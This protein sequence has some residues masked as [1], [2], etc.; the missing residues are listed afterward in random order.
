MPTKEELT[1][2][3][4]KADAAATAGDQSAAA[5]A[6]KLAQMIRDLDAAPVTPAAS[7][8]KAPPA[9][10]A[11][12]AKAPPMQPSN[13]GGMGPVNPMVE[14][15]LNAQRQALIG[16]AERYRQGKIDQVN[17]QR[18]PFQEEPVDVQ[19]VIADMDKSAADRSRREAYEQEGIRQNKESLFGSLGIPTGFDPKAYANTRMAGDAVVQDASKL[20]KTAHL[21]A[22]NGLV[23][24]A[25]SGINLLPDIA[26]GLLDVGGETKTT[27]RVPTADLSRARMDIAPEDQSVSGGLLEGLVQFIAARKTVGKAAPGGGIAPQIGKDALAVGVGFDGSTGRVA[28]MIDPSIIP[29]GPL[30]DYAE[31]LKTQPDDSPLVGRF[32]NMLEDMTLS[33]PAVVPQA[34]VAPAARALGNAINPPAIPTNAGGARPGPINT[35]AVMQPPAPAVPPT[36]PA[37]PPVQPQAAAQVAPPVAPPSSAPVQTATSPPVPP[38]PPVGGPPVAAGAVSPAAAVQAPPVAPALSRE[39]AR[40]ADLF[41]RKLQA[42]GLSMDDLVRIRNSMARRGDSGVY[43]TSGELAGLSG[44]SAGANL[45][46][47]QMAGGAAPGELQNALVG[48]VNENAAKMPDRLS[49]GATRATGQK[50]E[51]AVATLDELDQRLKTEAGPLYDAFYDAPIDPRIYDAEISPVLNAP[52]G[53][54]AMERA[55]RGLGVE[56]ASLQARVASGGASPKAQAAL[57][58]TYDAAEALRANIE[59]PQKLAQARKAAETGDA[60]AM[61]QLA[62]LEAN[63]PAAIPPM[64]LDHVK[65]AFDDLIDEAGQATYTGGNLRAAKRN[66]AESVSN[67]TG[68]AY[69]NALGTYEGIKRLEDAFDTG[70][71]ALTKK[72]WELERDLAK[73]RGGARFTGGEVEALSMGV[74][75]HIEDLIEANDQAALTK[76]LK[77]KALKNMAT[78]LGSE[79]AAKQFEQT[80][81]RLGANREWG[82]RVAGGSD[83]AMRTAAIRDAGMETEDA[84]TRVLDRVESS[85]NTF[86]LPGLAN[87]VAIKPIARA[88]KKLYQQM[89][90]PGVYDEGVNKALV[91]LIATPMT[92]KNLDEVIRIVEARQAQKGAKGRKAAPA[93]TQ[94]AAGRRKARTSPND[95][96]FAGITPL[97]TLTGASGG[98]LA[99]AAMPADSD[100]ER[101]MNALFGAGAGGVTLGGAAK[102]ATRKP[103]PAGNA[104]KSGPPK[105][106][107]MA[108]AGTKAPPAAMDA[109][110]RPSAS[111]SSV[112]QSR[113]VAKVATQDGRQ[114]DVTADVFKDRDAVVMSPAWPSNI[115][116]DLENAITHQRSTLKA[117]RNGMDVANDA[118]RAP[119]WAEQNPK[120]WADVQRQIGERFIGMVRSTPGPHILALVDGVDINSLGSM[121]EANMPAG[122][123]LLKSP[124]NVDLAVVSKGAR[125]E[126][127]QRWDTYAPRFNQNAG[128]LLPPADWANAKAPPASPTVKPSG[129]PKPPPVQKNAFPGSNA[130]VPAAAGAG[131]ATYGWNNPVD[132]NEDGV[133][134]DQDRMIT[135]TTL[136]LGSLTVAGVARSRGQIGT[137]GQL[138]TFG[139]PV[140]A[141]NLAAK[142]ELRPQQALDMADQMAAR[143]ATR[144]EI[145]DATAKH[146]EG[147]PYAGAVAGKHSVDGKPR[148]EID[149][150]GAK[151]GSEA[152]LVFGG[153]RAYPGS[154]KDVLEHPELYKAYPDMANDPAMI[155]RTPKVS[156]VYEGETRNAGAFGP[157]LQSVRS[158][159][160]HEAG[161]HG[162]QDVEGFAQGGSAWGTQAFAREQR[163]IADALVEIAYRAEKYPSE[164]AEDL[165]LAAGN[166]TNASEET[167]QRA[168]KVWEDA[169]RPSEAAAREIA[170]RHLNVAKGVENLEP[171]E[172]YRRLAGE[173]EARNVQARDEIRRRG[174]TPGRPWET[175]DVPDDQQIV[176]FGGGKAESRPKPPP[177]GNKLKPPPAQAG[178]GGGKGPKAPPVKKPQGPPKKAEEVALRN[179]LKKART[180]ETASRRRNVM[181]DNRDELNRPAE[182]AVMQ[183]ERDLNE[184]LD[185]QYRQKANQ[186]R[187]MDRGAS[188][189]QA[190]KK[191]AVATGNALKRS[192]LKNEAELAKATAASVVGIGAGAI[193]LRYI[194]GEDEGKRDEEALPP[195]H[196]RYFFEKMKRDKGLV[197]PVQDAL[198]AIG[199][200]NEKDAAGGWGSKTKDALAAWLALRPN[201]NKNLP[202]QDYEVPELLAEAYGGTQDEKGKWLYPDGEPIVYPLPAGQDYLPRRPLND[203]ESRYMQYYERTEAEK[204]K[205]LAGR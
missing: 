34:A 149:D 169:G 166:I 172:A 138:N 78:A 18:R 139:G 94:A 102:L 50:A 82:R 168:L 136:G 5:D 201:R 117:R 134:D 186:A 28:D 33:G 35:A 133:I 91:P 194:L 164:S 110:A 44:K 75:R 105:P 59:Y 14:M 196:P 73:G 8:A 61:S 173:A 129:A 143:G 23:Q 151:I 42:D 30:R 191:A 174:E 74:A 177:T 147:T 16:E 2:A 123:L 70:L 188:A 115:A 79:K 55:A 88:G 103:R 13:G 36:R 198:V 132:A 62:A 171:F 52:H 180:A 187:W 98:A 142:G 97:A 96:G 200:L 141:K 202:I 95:A 63:R 24:A 40:A 167:I 47:L 12:A 128:L 197:A 71:S 107:A 193:G 58:R 101:F 135:A 48:L 68:G 89:R 199:M 9:S 66:F 43:E 154:M 45:R 179:A 65:R 7:A 19:Q 113:S 22:W 51:N 127:F 41:I 150:S 6:R 27:N 170:L 106:P 131:G 83:T 157:D 99:G 114:Y 49:R 116:E 93:P 152:S 84:V 137:K 64:A 53:Q 161:G 145:W 67:A 195:T 60:A 185:R 57:Q 39:E 90:Y 76:L 163:Q 118:P 146:L 182:E 77:G 190:G 25:Q 176:R 31:F 26:Q 155:K 192:I 69:G 10:M 37:P 159:M 92:P 1:L 32:K 165:I 153:S 130:V 109:P 29:E 148:F 120:E 100:E 144:D 181:R 205:K 108:E 119:D 178:F 72:T 17:A 20:G 38:Q 56:A 86:S 81:R 203:A 156:G 189:A 158:T 46:G 184:Y 112:P 175:Q 54:A 104:L 183:A 204:R 121:I 111:I 140:A 126:Q 21:N 87:D 85:G 3:L 11:P 80:I 4:T 122:K 15:G 125:P 124:D 162:A 160:L